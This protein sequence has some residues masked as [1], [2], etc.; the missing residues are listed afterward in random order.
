M[1]C[2][3]FYQSLSLIATHGS[4]ATNVYQSRTWQ[5]TTLQILHLG[6]ESGS[7]AA[8]SLC[9]MRL[10]HDCILSLWTLKLRVTYVVRMTEPSP[11]SRSLPNEPKARAKFEL[12]IH[13]ADTTT[14]LSAFPTWP[15][16][17]VRVHGGRRYGTRRKQALHVLA[18]LRAREEALHTRSMQ[19]TQVITY[20]S[21]T[22]RPTGRP[23]L[24]A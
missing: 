9:P 12:H 22:L 15:M 7:Q 1:P 16:S 2:S 4:Q 17:P 24:W 10:R 5:M 21:P 18:M 19:S 8:T 6:P 13:H 11:V 3:V 14:P 23:T 20:I